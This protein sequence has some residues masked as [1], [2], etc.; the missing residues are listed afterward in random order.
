M[1][2]LGD[3]VDKMLA[4]V[5][6]SE[7]DRLCHHGELRT[8]CA[9]CASEALRIRRDELEMALSSL[10]HHWAEFGPEYGFDEVV[11]RAGKVLRGGK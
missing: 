10:V 3:A 2:D 6:Q 4:D 9:Q 1:S 8:H 5:P 7:W 11:E